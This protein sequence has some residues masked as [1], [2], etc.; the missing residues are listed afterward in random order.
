MAW[1]QPICT[2]NSED[3][4]SQCY[5]R[6]KYCCVIFLVAFRNVQEKDQ[7]IGQCVAKIN[8]CKGN[9]CNWKTT[10]CIWLPFQT[11][12]VWPK[13][14]SWECSLMERYSYIW[15]FVRSRTFGSF[16]LKHTVNSAGYIC[17]I[18]A[19]WKYYKGLWGAFCFFFVFT[20]WIIETKLNWYKKESNS[21]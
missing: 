13:E 4:H 17:F 16:C 3:R 12:E 21:W 2:C 15:A 6:V 8:T 14:Y 1:Q 19:L 18:L 10:P 7:N 11:G 20:W 9:K 5:T